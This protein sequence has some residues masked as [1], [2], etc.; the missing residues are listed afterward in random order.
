MYRKGQ[1]SGNT[2]R[3][4]FAD[5]ASEVAGHQVFLSEDT[6]ELIV[7]DYNG[8]YRTYCLGS[9]KVATAVEDSKNLME[10][11]EMCQRF[12]LAV[13]NQIDERSVTGKLDDIEALK[14]ARAAKKLISPTSSTPP[15]QQQQQQQQHQQSKQRQQPLKYQQPQPRRQPQKRQRTTFVKGLP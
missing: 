12:A 9:F 11:F 13:K 1:E 2:G 3:G 15:K 4:K 7:I 8:M 6:T 14:L 10:C 5:G